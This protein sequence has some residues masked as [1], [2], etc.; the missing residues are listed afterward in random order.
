MSLRKRVLAGLVCLSVVGAFVALAVSSCRGTQN[1]FGL[2]E[3]ESRLSSS[4]VELPT[5]PGIGVDIN[6]ILQQWSAGHP[7]EAVANFLQLYDE[8]APDSS[9][10]PFDLSEHQFVLLPA[11]E[12]DP[13]KQEMLAKFAI[14]Q[15]FS[16]ELQSQAKAAVA[17]GDYARAK[18]LL[19][20][21][22]QL[23]QANTGPEV[24]LLAN[25]VGTAIEA[26]ANQELAE[27]DDAE[28]RGTP[29]P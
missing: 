19:L 16:R 11:G 1:E 4:G 10:R 25:L 14:L 22:K 29:P 28:A 12:R 7:D 5:T 13:L 3:D 17:A 8:D 6:D 24:T 26:L 20:A 15:K 27:L 21:M 2:T 18:R 9:Y 23:G